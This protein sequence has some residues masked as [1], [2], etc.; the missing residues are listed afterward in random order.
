M[1]NRLRTA[2]VV[3]AAL[4]LAVGTYL[5]YDKYS[6]RNHVIG[7]VSDAGA[8][9]Y[10]VLQA[11]VGDAASVDLEAHAT[12]LEGYA[13]TLRR[14]NTSSFTP[15]ADA[16]DDYLVTAREI[17]RRSVEMRRA[18][19]AL[20]ASVPALSAH[21]KADRGAASWTGEAMKLKQSLDK[22]FR[23]YRIAVE[24]YRSLLGSLGSSQEKVA[25]YIEGLQIADAALVRKAS[26]GA[27]DAYFAT[28][29]NVKQVANL[30]AYGRR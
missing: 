1:Q 5:A 21:I 10:N 30:G 6:R 29:Q 24:A 27:L 20:D 15:L 12:V 3:I 9:L 4:V 13:A 8:R 26:A 28:E 18:R 14:M 19:T 16:A 25:A 11:Q 23:D 17:A 22:D 7:M 2:A